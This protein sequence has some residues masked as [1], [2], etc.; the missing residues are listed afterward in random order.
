MG[1]VEQL[2][3]DFPTFGAFGIV[4]LAIVSLVVVVGV[5]GYIADTGKGVSG[6]TLRVGGVLGAV[7]IFFAGVFDLTYQ[8]SP[9]SVPRG[10]F[11]VSFGLG[12]FVCA[13]LAPR[14]KLWRWLGGSYWDSPRY[15][16]PRERVQSGETNS[17]RTGSK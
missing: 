2:E 10:L 8:P 17:R 14:E 16:S 11:A 12:F 3:T 9:T 7:L 1:I 15:V 4:L 13:L 6:L 5:L